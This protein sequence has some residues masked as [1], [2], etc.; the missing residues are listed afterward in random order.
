MTYRGTD[1]LVL[2]CTTRITDAGFTRIV[3][4]SKVMQ[5]LNKQDGLDFL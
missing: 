5:P 3:A 2:F 4:E 1:H